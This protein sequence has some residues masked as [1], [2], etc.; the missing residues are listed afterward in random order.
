MTR[1]DDLVLEELPAHISDE[2]EAARILAA[3]AAANRLEKVLPPPDTDAGQFRTRVR[4]LRAWVPELDLP[5]FD[6]A[7]LNDTIESLCRGK[8]SLV[9]V[10]NGP[11]LDV[12]KGRLSYEQL[13]AVEVGGAGAHRGAER[14]SR[15]ASSTRRA[16]RRCWRRGS[17][18]CSASPRRRGSRAGG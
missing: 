18:R 9:E 7:D 10:R 16:G 1:F 4:C 11:W 15:F 2:D 17:R 13:R 3:A 12:L 14:Q 8:R 5:A 6:A